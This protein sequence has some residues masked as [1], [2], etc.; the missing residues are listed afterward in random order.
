[1]SVFMLLF[2]V[3]WLCLC[4]HAC[5]LVNFCFYLSWAQCNFCFEV[6]AERFIKILISNSIFVFFS[7][8]S[9]ACCSEMGKRTYVVTFFHWCKFF[10]SFTIFKI[11]CFLSLR[12]KMSVSVYFDGENKLWIWTKLRIVKWWVLISLF[13]FITW[14]EAWPLGPR[15]IL[16]Y[17]NIIL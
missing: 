1:M 9:D 4:I 13:G 17:I 2:L 12:M 6:L 14:K 5:I 11:P 16:V 10:N 7:W 15:L 3:E 8:C